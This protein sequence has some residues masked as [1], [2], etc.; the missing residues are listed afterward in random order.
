MN[1]TGVTNNQELI[2]ILESD[3]QSIQKLNEAKAELTKND[4]NDPLIASIDSILDIYKQY[5]QY[6]LNLALA[7]KQQKA[8]ERKSMATFAYYDNEASDRAVGEE[9]TNFNEI[10]TNY[11]MRRWKEVGGELVDYLTSNESADYEEFESQFQEFWQ[12]L[13]STE[14]EAFNSL[15]GN[16]GMYSRSQYQQALIDA[17]VDK[18]LQNELMAQWVEEY[19]NQQ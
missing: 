19:S 15:L 16:Q 5:Q 11:L 9:I 4:S 18:D 7:E 3:A 8:T 1:F 12:T 2:G 14:K 10:A 13:S 6:K 17:G